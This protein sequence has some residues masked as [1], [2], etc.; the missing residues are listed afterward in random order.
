MQELALAIMN[1]HAGFFIASPS[2]YLET[3]PK[4]IYHQ[5]K[6]EIE[7][8]RAYFWYLYT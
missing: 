4:A 3:M 2:L 5:N 6:F 7:F 8:Y 1:E